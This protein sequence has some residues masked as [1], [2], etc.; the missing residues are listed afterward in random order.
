MVSATIVEVGQPRLAAQR[1]ELPADEGVGGLLRPAPDDLGGE[2][3]VGAVDG[4]QAP[5]GVDHHDPAAGSGDAHELGDGGARCVQVLEDALAHRAVEAGVVEVEVGD[6]TVSE[7]DRERGGGGPAP[8]F[9]E[10]GLAG[11]DAQHGAGW[12]DATDEGAGE[13]TGPATDLHDL[14]TEPDA[15]KVGGC[16]AAVV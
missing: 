15:E 12:A 10:H 4:V 11:V 13:V 7:L 16:G 5:V 14:V 8:G 2:P 1:S 3:G 9:G 6:V